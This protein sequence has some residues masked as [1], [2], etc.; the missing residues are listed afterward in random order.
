M[1]HRG[2]GGW[3]RGGYSALGQQVYQAKKWTKPGSDVDAQTAAAAPP[4]AATQ[5]QIGADDA[6]HVQGGADAARSAHKSL[7]V[8][9]IGGGGARKWVKGQG[10]IGP[11][12]PPPRPPPPERG[13]LSIFVGNLDQSVT[14]DNLWRFFGQAGKVNSVKVMP[15]KEGKPYVIAFVNYADGTLLGKCREVLKVLH[16]AFVIMNQKTH[17]TINM[18]QN[19]AI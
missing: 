14:E 8:G 11:A 19:D 15:R 6:A 13:R 2:R 1:A 10:V 12:P 5:V 16:T 18:W 4:P 17:N 7:A 3:G 9:A